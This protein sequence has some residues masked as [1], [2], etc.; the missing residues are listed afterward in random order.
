MQTNSGFAGAMRNLHG[1]GC[2]GVSGLD[3]LPLYSLS[4]SHETALT[5]CGTVTLTQP[6]LKASAQEWNYLKGRH[7]ALLGGGA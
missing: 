6:E 5:V 4:K 1:N 2:Y 7:S 3:R